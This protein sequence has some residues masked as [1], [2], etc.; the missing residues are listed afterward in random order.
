MAGFGRSGVACEKRQALADVL[1]ELHRAER[2]LACHGWSGLN[3]FS[4][5]QHPHRHGGQRASSR[6]AGR[7]HGLRS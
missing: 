7:R 2:P 3:R 4:S 5:K 6:R 1:A